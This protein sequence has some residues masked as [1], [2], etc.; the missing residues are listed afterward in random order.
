MRTSVW[1]SGPTKDE[2]IRQLAAFIQQCQCVGDSQHTL[3][4]NVS[5][6]EA[7]RPHISVTDTRKIDASTV[8]VIFDVQYEV[9]RDFQSTW[10]LTENAKPLLPFDGKKGTTVNVTGIKTT[11]QRSGPRMLPLRRSRMLRPAS[12]RAWRL[13]V[14]SETEPPFADL[15]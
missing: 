15:W 7:V 12:S 10:N 9:L 2:A 8:E 1:S 4:V 5:L 3:G 14:S 11:F 6:S 13:A